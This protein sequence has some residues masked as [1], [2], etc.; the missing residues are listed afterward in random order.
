MMIHKRDSPNN[1]DYFTTPIQSDR[2][3]YDYGRTQWQD[4]PKRD[5]WMLPALVFTALVVVWFLW[6]Y[7]R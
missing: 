5:P 2:T 7:S 1:R 3:H 6:Q 4:E